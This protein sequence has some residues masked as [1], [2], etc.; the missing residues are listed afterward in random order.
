MATTQT[1]LESGDGGELKG[2]TIGAVNE[3]YASRVIA[4]MVNH[5]RLTYGIADET[6]DEHIS[7]I[8]VVKDPIQ[9]GDYAIFATVTDVDKVTNARSLDLFGFEIVESRR[10]SITDDGDVIHTFAG[11]R[12]PE[13]GDYEIHRKDGM[14]ASDSATKCHVEVVM[15]T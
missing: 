5:G 6:A 2:A 8:E 7:E 14:V 13:N 11:F 10:V 1:E 9:N 4:A 12:E 15:E 3:Q